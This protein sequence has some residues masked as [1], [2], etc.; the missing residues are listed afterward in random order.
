MVNQA[1]RDAIL[2][3]FKNTGQR[4]TSS[5]VADELGLTIGAAKYYLTRLKDEGLVHS[6][7][8]GPHGGYALSKTPRRKGIETDLKVLDL[9]NAQG[10]LTSSQVADALDMT[11]S[12]VAQRLHRL[13][14]RGA[15]VGERTGPNRGYRIAE[16]PK[17]VTVPALKKA[18]RDKWDQEDSVTGGAQQIADETQSF[19]E[20][21][22]PVE[23]VKEAAAVR[24][25][26]YKDVKVTLED[27]QGWV[28]DLRSS[29]TPPRTVG[30][31]NG[32]VTHVAVNPDMFDKV[33][34]LPFPVGVAALA[35]LNNDVTTARRMLELA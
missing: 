12:A 17:V 32:D 3:L 2:N 34:D 6:L 11:Q 21:S 16:K 9:L 27:V 13:Q 14:T 25:N 8:R 26:P 30:E 15:V 23:A 19:F 31:T 24:E 22:E 28:T 10:P 35:L 18:L 7:G 5:E 33:K 1:D 4:Y 29:F 20:Q